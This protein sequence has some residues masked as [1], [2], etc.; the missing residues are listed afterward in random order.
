MIHRRKSAAKKVRK[1]P[2]RRGMSVSPTRRRRR[3]GA[4]AGGAGGGSKLRARFATLGPKEKRAAARRIA[5]L[6]GR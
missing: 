4:G 5:R 2:M 3:G 6:R 1:A